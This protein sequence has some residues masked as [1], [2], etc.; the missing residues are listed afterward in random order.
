M[1]GKQIPA[2]TMTPVP[3]RISGEARPL[4]ELLVHF[5]MPINPAL[6]SYPQMLL[7]FCELILGIPRQL[8]GNGTQHDVETL[9]GQ[10][11]QL[12]RSATVLKPYWENVQDEHAH[13]SQNAIECL[14]TLMKAGAVTKIKDVVESQG[15][16]FQNNEVDWTSMQG[17]VE[18]SS[19]ESQDLPVNP[20]ELKAA[21]QAIF[22]ELAKNNPA[23]AE[24]F[25]VPANQDLAESLMLPGSVIPNEAQRLKTEA[26]IQTLIDQGPEV[27]EN[28][29]GSIGSDLPA[30]PGKW[31]DIPVAKKVLGRYMNEH[32][33]LRTEKPDR[34]IALAQYWDELDDMDMQVASNAAKRQM[35]VTEAGKPPAPAPDPT[36]QSEMQQLIA[37]AGPAIQRLLQLAQID[38]AFTKGTASAQVSAAKEIVDSTVKGAELMAKS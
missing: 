17:S 2:G 6:W 9:G 15:G 20:D 33:E 29:D 24:W 1:S 18:F 21:I 22:E 13:A 31:E 4:S 25:D 16:A 3:M 7:T 8:S 23:A 34:W 26:D 19:D 35:Q 11:L 10:Q 37:V 32:F 14:Q 12:D 36:A 28:P 38:P 5:D 30:H 27:K